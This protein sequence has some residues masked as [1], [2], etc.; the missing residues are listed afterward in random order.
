MQ[1]TAA[2]AS[3]QSTRVKRF[4]PKRNCFRLP[5]QITSS[6]IASRLH[7]LR[8][9]DA[10]SPAPVSSPPASVG[11]ITPSQSLRAAP[12]QRAAAALTFGENNVDAKP[13]WLYLV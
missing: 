12:C 11:R 6:I 13:R 10:P 3:R 8:I 4:H 9:A 1:E 5:R 7:T 2:R